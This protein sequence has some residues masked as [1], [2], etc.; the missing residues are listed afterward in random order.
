[1][2]SPH[3]DVSFFP[4][5]R[6][7]GRAKVEAARLS[8]AQGRRA[9]RPLGAAAAVSQAVRQVDAS[10]F[11]LPLPPPPPQTS[12]LH[13]PSTPLFLLHHH[14]LYKGQAEGG[15]DAASLPS[16]WCRMPLSGCQPAHSNEG[17]HQG[18]CRLE[19]CLAPPRLLFPS[20][21]P[22]GFHLLSLSA[23]PPWIPCKNYSRCSILLETGCGANGGNL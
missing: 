7:Q 12:S 2:A 20:L 11:P 14:L 13:S 10:S 17:C 4:P 5:F 6:R 18:Y 8:E 1:M 21:P 19:R 15:S 16:I 23:V 22:S 3:G 9:A